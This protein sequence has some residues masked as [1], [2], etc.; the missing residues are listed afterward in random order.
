MP[1]LDRRH[2]ELYAPFNQL[3]EFQVGYEDYLNGRPCPFPLRSVKGQ[4]WD[5]GAE[6]AATDARKDREY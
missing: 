3:E 6:A 2:D 5:R 1:I 4:A